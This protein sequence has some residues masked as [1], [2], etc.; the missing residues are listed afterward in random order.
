MSTHKNLKKLR[1]KRHMTKKRNIR[2]P[3]NKSMPVDDINYYKDTAT[4]LYELE[5]AKDLVNGFKQMRKTMAYD[6]CCVLILLILFTT[7][8]ALAII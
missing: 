4:K 8:V 1:R 7:M 6:T 3:E 2:C 5:T